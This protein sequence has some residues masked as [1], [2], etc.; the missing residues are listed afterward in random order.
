M[1]PVAEAN[2]EVPEMLADVVD[3]LLAADFSQRP[4][5]AGQAAKRLRII[6]ASEEETREHHPEEHLSAVTEPPRET[7]P[8]PAEPA[9]AS[10]PPAHSTG[11]LAEL[12]QE[13]R[14]GARDLFFLG[15]GAAAII[16]LT[17]LARLLFGFTFVNVVCL[18]TGAALSYLV[19]RWLRLRETE[20]VALNEEASHSE[21]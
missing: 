13:L 7:S 19:E 2:P 1:R 16:L 3:Q 17:L 18:V 11:K 5:N 4:R 14:P 10:P 9:A 15:A 6:L 8:I 20:G 21:S 12:W